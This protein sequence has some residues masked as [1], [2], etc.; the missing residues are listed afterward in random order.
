[1]QIIQYFL[2]D[3]KELMDSAYNL[4]SNLNYIV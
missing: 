3:N 1:M 4:I 2:L